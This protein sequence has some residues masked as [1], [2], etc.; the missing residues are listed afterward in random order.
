MTN[1]LAGET[2]PYLLQHAD[3]PVEWFPWGEEAFAESVRRDVPIFLSI[4]YSTCHWC[5]VMARESFDDQATA[6]VLNARFVCVKVDREERPDVDSIYVAAVQAISKHGGW[7]MSLFLSP[8]GDLFYAGS[9][10]P[11]VAH[12]GHPAFVD[13]AE[14]VARA[15]HDRRGAVTASVRA[16][17][18]RLSQAQSAPSSASDVQLD[19][20]DRAAR[21]VLD[22]LW[23][24]QHGGF[25]QAP[26]FPQAMTI[27]W[28]LHRYA[29]T[30]DQASLDA[31][32]QAL[33]AMARGGI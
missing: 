17:S 33:D 1:R 14:A 6:D 27:E 23:D 31:S 29:R 7:P 28:L 30:F 20:V 24:T 22:T 4:G 21:T 26:K 3:N 10:W 25:G 12:D 8:Q 9:Y 13:V 15:W 2:S 16:V 5:H 19:V 32:V 11:K 18:A